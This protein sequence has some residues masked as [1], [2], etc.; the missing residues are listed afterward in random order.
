MRARLR[1]CALLV[2]ICVLL[3]VTACHTDEPPSLR[4]CVL[5]VGQSDCI[6]LSFGEEHLLVDT[7]TAAARDTVLASLSR[8]GVGELTLLVTH[9]HEDHYGNARP[10]LE[11][12]PVSALMLPSCESAEL[13]W[14]MMLEAAI[15]NEVPIQKPQHGSTFLLGEATVEVL[16][17]LPEAENPNNACLVL[18]VRYG[19]CTLLLMGD[20]ERECELALL[21]YLPV[22][23]VCDLLKVGHHGS[24]TATSPELLAHLTPHL[25]AISCGEDNEFAFP[26]AAVL[27]GLEGVGAT[28]YR[29]D[30]H[31][32]LVFTCDGTEVTCHGS[33]N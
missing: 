26:H 3:S 8:L 4:I 11:T 25:A 20:A 13:G 16:C 6:L 33:K 27:Q 7:G 17:P 28:V 12:Y 15:G 22:D 29:T 30:L 21:P 19:S 23:T 31:G 24:D 14:R 5:D 2:C 9:P 32:E 10:V 18:C 1:F